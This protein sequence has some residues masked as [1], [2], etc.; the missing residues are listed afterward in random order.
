MRVFVLCTGRCGSTTLAKA[1]GHI[2]NYTVGHETGR[3][4]GY[5]LVYPRHHIEVDNRLSWFLGRL[6]EKYPDAFYLHLRRNVE[7][8]SKSFAARGARREGGLLG[9]FILALKQGRSTE[10]PSHEL[11]SAARQLVET[12]EANL[13]HFL[14]DK[15]HM[16]VSIESAAATFADF[17]KRIAAEGNLPAALEELTRRYNR[18]PTP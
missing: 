1:C 3:A 9:G 16:V 10:L 4:T 13:R 14:R 7:A 11:E 18:G 2:T 12:I 17:W 15:P 8:V 5:D 6:N